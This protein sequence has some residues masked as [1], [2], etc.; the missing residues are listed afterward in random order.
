M[1]A[2]LVEQEV[3]TYHYAEVMDGVPGAVAL[4]CMVVEVKVV[5]AVAVEYV[6]DAEIEMA[7]EGMVVEE[8]H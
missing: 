1:F 8:E 7:A 2:V 5:G 4:V 6:V 3:V